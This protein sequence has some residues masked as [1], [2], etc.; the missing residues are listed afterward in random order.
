[1]GLKIILPNVSFTDLSLPVLPQYDAIESVGSLFL[2]DPSN[3]VGAFSG[4]PGISGPI[5]NVLWSKAAAVLGS[6][7]NSSLSGVVSRSDA[8]APN[9]WLK[10]RS[11]KGG[12][13]CIS[14]QAGSQVATGHAWVAGLP[15]AIRAYIRANLPGHG[16]YF[17]IWRKITRAPL[18]SV[19]VASV[20]HGASNTTD[21]VFHTSNG[22]FTGAGGSNLVSPTGGDTSLAAGTNSFLAGSVNAV[23]G[24]GGAPTDPFNFGTGTFD[25][26]SSFN[27]NKAHSQIIYRV[28]VEDLTVSGRTFATVSA[29]DKSLFDQAFGTGGRFAGDT[30]TNPSTLL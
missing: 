16:F 20:F 10:E 18:P 4:V 2:M 19:G 9:L 11:G 21:F 15:D 28:Y 30:Y 29:L 14:T 1:M 22:N 23:S 5:P 24:T 26:W 13:H 27:Y 25:A 7:N 6:G 3:A 12:I 17:S 8:N